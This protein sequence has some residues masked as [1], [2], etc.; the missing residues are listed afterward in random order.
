MTDFHDFC[1]YVLRNA[2]TVPRA[3]PKHIFSHPLHF[4]IIKNYILTQQ[5]PGLLKILIKSTQN[6]TDSYLLALFILNFF[7]I[8][9]FLLCFQDWKGTFCCAEVREWKLHD[10]SLCLCV[11]HAFENKCHLHFC[12]DSYIG[13]IYALYML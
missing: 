13:V 10:F 12:T 6:Q 7:F 4:I 5:P 2:V 1:Q 3:S 9:F 11:K 8:L